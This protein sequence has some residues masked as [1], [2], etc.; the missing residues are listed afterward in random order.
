MGSDMGP[1]A[2]G[3]RGGGAG[4]VD[5]A[6]QGVGVPADDEGPPFEMAADVREGAVLFVR[7][8]FT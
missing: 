7:G 2:Q 8:E 5:G 1:E 3:P 6:G 4:G